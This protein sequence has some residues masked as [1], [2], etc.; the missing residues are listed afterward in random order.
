[1]VNAVLSIASFHYNDE[2]IVE[3]LHSSWF[4]ESQIW[5]DMSCHLEQPLPLVQ[6]DTG[7]PRGPFGGLTGYSLEHASFHRDQA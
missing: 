3:P 4:E 7:G 2:D 1:M 6:L 5:R